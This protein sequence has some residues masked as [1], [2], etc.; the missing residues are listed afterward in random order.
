MSQ[1]SAVGI[2]TG[3][4]PDD[5]GIVVKFLAGTDFYL[6]HCVQNDSRVNLAPDTCIL[7][8]LSLR[9]KQLGHEAI[10]HLSHVWLTRITH[11]CDTQGGQP[12]TNL[13]SHLS[14]SGHRTITQSLNACCLMLSALRV[15]MLSCPCDTY[16]YSWQCYEICSEMKYTDEQG[17]YSFTISFY[18]ILRGRNAIESSVGK[19]PD[20]IVPC[21]AMIYNMVTKLCSMG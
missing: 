8:S 5:R 4:G 11:L 15:Q 16:K 14:T 17:N 21:K 20:S 1:V 2:V 13:F 7:G 19:C 3:Y 6:F 10:P 18:N 9:E 12:T